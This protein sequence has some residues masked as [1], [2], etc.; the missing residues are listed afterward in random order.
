MLADKPFVDSFTIITTDANTTL[1]PLHHRM[2][3]ILAPEDYATW[4]EPDSAPEDLAA[5]LRPAPD[6]RLGFAPADRRVNSV[7]NDDAE[8]LRAPEAATG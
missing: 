5:L 4:L 8:L 7:R 6:D 3:V 1:K 2:P